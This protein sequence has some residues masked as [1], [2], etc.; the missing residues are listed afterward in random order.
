[1]GATLFPRTA[2]RW[3]LLPLLVLALALGLTWLVWSHE[4]ERSRA[5]LRT[6]FDFAVRETVSRV[7]QRMAAYEQ[8]LRG[9]QALFAATGQP[10]RAAL[11]AYVDTLQLDA[12]F[13]GIQD[14]G[15]VQHLSASARDEHVAA[16]RQLGLDDYVIYPE[17]Q[18]DS[19]A[20]IVQREPELRSALAP[21]GFDAW[22]EPV[23]RQAMERA[24]D[25]GMAALSGK[26]RL[27]VDPATK[28]TPSF[29]LYLPVFQPGQPRGSVTQRR[30]HLVGWVYASFHMSDFVASL[31]GALAPG[32]SVAFFDDVVLSDASLLYRSADYSAEPQT[33]AGLK[34]NANEYL[35]IAG[36]TWTLSVSALKEFET[37][38][39]RD[40]SPVIAITGIWLSLMLAVL[41]WLL[42]TGRDRAVRMAERM[43]EELRHMA[44]HDSLTG[45]PNRALFSDR[46]NQELSR[47]RRHE[48]RFAVMFL[49]LDNFK[50]INDSFGH[51]V[52][53]LLLQQVARRLRVAIRESDTIGRIGGDEF[54]VLMPELAETEAALNVAEK[55]REAL[56]QPFQVE[57]HTLLISCS[58][59]IAIYPDDGTDEIALT[60][61]ADQA[62]YRDK[63]SGRDQ[64]ALRT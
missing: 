37:S 41:A 60:K 38:L 20:P 17:G 22:S 62:M 1:M 27:E 7:D 40:T 54:V 33:L 2:V 57:D 21:L 61:S 6:Q 29:I 32:L 10:D 4:R 13:S 47:A 52:G 34:F 8:L 36:H 56:R 44:Q 24:R 45:L 9:V 64:T 5:A 35:V 39:G 28:A 16:M 51:A 55:I 26:V 43:T 25:S 50:P 12:N 53:D 18:R 3:R 49:D 15:V 23:R 48:D 46:L 30:A 58:V 63:A 31:Y 59:G 11:R 42:S 19:Y 14:I